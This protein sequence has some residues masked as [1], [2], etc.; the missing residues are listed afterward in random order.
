MS[1]TADEQ[2]PRRQLESWAFERLRAWGE[3]QKHDYDFGSWAKGASKNCL[4][5]GAVYEYARESQKLRGLLALMNPKRSRND[6][7]IM[8][9]ASIDGRKPQ[10]GEIESYPAE[11]TWLPCSFEGLDEH[12]AEKALGGF[13]YCLSDLA[14]YLADNI[15]FGELFRTK[16]DDLENAFGCLNDLARAKR[17]FRYFL[18]VDAV[19]A[20]ELAT[21]SEAER[22]TVE[23]TLFDDEKRTIRGDSCS[24]VIAVKIRWRFT[25]SDIARA[26][27][28]LARTVRPKASKP[29]QR[30]KGSRQESAR[31]A[32]D[33]L[34]A[35]RLASYVRKTSPATPR[36]LA[37]YLAGE[38]HGT[39]FEPSA[40]ELFEMARLGGHGKRIAESNFDALIIEARNV[41]KESFPF[42]EDAANAPTLAAR[43]MMKSERISSQDKT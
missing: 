5:A 31:A 42:G 23:E 7:E 22:A 36:Q 13:L 17:E 30:K 41:F 40:I 14:D 32:L 35:M 21:E 34:S 10:P 29:I 15:S 12:E 2:A 4:R 18:A 37:S 16:R 27:G 28:R 26:M 24:E 25:N 39:K 33:A 3:L 11:A 38:L 8:R 20:V 1:D 9:P 6:W 19:D 43:I